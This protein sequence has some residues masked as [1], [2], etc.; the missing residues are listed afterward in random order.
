MALTLILAAVCC[1]AGAALYAYACESKRVPPMGRRLAKAIPGAVCAAAVLSAYLRGEAPYGWLPALALLLC[2]AADYILE[3]T[4]LPGMAVFALAHILLCVY[5]PL[6]GVSVPVSACAA[7][8]L[9]ALIVLLF[10]KER[11]RPP[12]PHAAYA[13][14]L[15]LMVSLAAGRDLLTFLGAACFLVSDALLAMR[16]LAGKFNGR[17]GGIAVMALYYSALYLICLGGCLMI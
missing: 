8:V 5:M 4:F 1:C 10:A 17:R 7:A 11:I 14:L 9:L 15:C 16:I 2:A 3:L 6:R 12:A 13:L